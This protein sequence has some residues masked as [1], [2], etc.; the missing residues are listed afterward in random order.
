[1]TMMIEHKPWAF[2][3][4]LASGDGLSVWDE[5]HYE[6]GSSFTTGSGV[7]VSVRRRPYWQLCDCG[8]RKITWQN[9]RVA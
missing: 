8:A 7:C 1:M 5:G 2:I 6:N 9:R 4:A 3:H